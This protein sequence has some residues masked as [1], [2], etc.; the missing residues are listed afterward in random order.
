MM[1][2]NKR[3]QEKITQFS[4]QNQNYKKNA[5]LN[6]IQD[7]LFEMKSSGMSW[8]AIMDA[9]PAYGL[10]VSDSSF[11]KFLKKSREQE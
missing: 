7:D 6:H 10:M 5:M 11:K 1:Y 9:L 2:K 8:N 4:L 3:L